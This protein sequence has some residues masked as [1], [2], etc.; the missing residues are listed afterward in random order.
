M[1]NLLRAC[2][3]LPLVLV[4]ASHV[5]VLDAATLS[6]KP[7]VKRFDVRDFGA[8]SDGSEDAQPAIRLAVDAA[9]TWTDAAP[10][11]TRRAIVFFPR[12]SYALSTVRTPYA[13]NLDGLH[14]VSLEGEDCRDTNGMYCVKLIGASWRFD[15][16]TST[17]VGNGYINV[18]DSQHI[19]V[20]NFYFDRQKPYFSQG[21]VVAVDPSQR[22]M[23]LRFDDG[24][25]DFTD[26]VIE[27]VYKSINVITDPASG[28][29]DHSEAACVGGISLPPGVAPCLNFHIVRN[30]H[31]PSGMWRVWLDRTPPSEFA[32][33]PFY[34]WR[35][36]GWPKAVF[37]EA[38]S[39]VTIEDIFYTGGGGS[40]AHLQANDGDIA[41]RHFAIDIPPGSHRL[42]SATSGFN[43]SRNRG[44]VTLDQVEMAHTDDDGFHFNE[45]N[46]FPA[47]EQNP[48]RTTVRV[49]LC[50]DR[51]FRP[52]DRIAAWDW[53]EKREIG[54]ATVVTA[55]V[56]TDGQFVRYPSTCD[57]QLDRP[58]PVL[59][60][61][62]TYDKSRLG[63]LKDTNAR[64]V[65]L[66]IRSF[67]T[68]TGSRLSSTRARCG[69]IQTP[70][71]ISNNTCTAVLA[72]LLVGPEFSWG[73]GY[74]VDD[75][76][77]VDN[78]FTNISGTAIYI[79][80]IADSNRSPTYKDLISSQP[81]KTNA[82]RDNK[83]IVI[84]GNSFSQLG[85]FGY[86]IMGIRGVAISVENAQ[87]VVIRNNR[88]DV[89]PP[90]QRDAPAPVVVSPTTTE[91]IQ[92]Q[93][94]AATK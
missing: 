10:P 84:E 57:I 85:R 91:D 63:Q 19:Q 94:P 28:S 81:P 13:I 49:D 22:T 75:V 33:H 47:L 78:H 24:F 86:G 3:L 31:L 36:I 61:M 64:I 90:S 71:L 56:A 16:R 68:V 5:P 89:Q 45:E 82:T 42:F 17:A 69:I 2:R 20:R 38:S 70:A 65:N 43:G 54:Q 40:G 59:S 1:A 92:V 29:Y 93:N 55:S 11:G 18:H 8:K 34:M 73:E 15:S 44:H 4:F 32:Q 50:Y 27:Y 7:T 74:A 46:Y 52:G 21:T 41:I 39:D 30:E 83:R 88:F 53:K 48:G 6:N 58:L 76:T 60:D 80:D 35:N 9:R 72:G 23:E 87:D 77:I 67:L 37:V 62:R 12:G 14:D 51:D 26:P 25:P 79:A 66:G